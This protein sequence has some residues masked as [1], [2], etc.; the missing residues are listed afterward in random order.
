MA[1]VLMVQE[2][3]TTL[4][5]DL[6]VAVRAPPPQD[7][8]M[9]PPE[10]ICA[11][12]PVPTLELDPGAVDAGDAWGDVVLCHLALLGVVCGSQLNFWEG[13]MSFYTP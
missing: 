2:V 12:L 9:N 1:P 10:V 4:A 7:L 3:P 5:Q 13:Y 11:P 6:V 8:L